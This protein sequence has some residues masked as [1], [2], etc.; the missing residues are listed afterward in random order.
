MH[1]IPSYALPCL[2]IPL[3]PPPT[4]PLQHLDKEKAA[5]R[6]LQEVAEKQKV[7][8]E[9]V[10]AQAG[11]LSSACCFCDATLLR[12]SNPASSTYVVAHLLPASSLPLQLKKIISNLE[13]T[14]EQVRGASSRFETWVCHHAAVR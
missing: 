3:T 11:R 7:E 9:K 6:K 5:Q 10:G 2:T 13:A 14:R 8:A 1:G 12:C 4:R